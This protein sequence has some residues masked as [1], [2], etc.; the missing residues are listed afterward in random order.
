MTLR[1]SLTLY[2]LNKAAYAA[3][4]TWSE[5]L[6]A[7]FGKNAGDARYDQRGRSTPELAAARNAYHEASAAQHAEWQKTLIYSNAR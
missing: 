4:K 6:R 1:Q 5:L 3:D 2:Q 7:A